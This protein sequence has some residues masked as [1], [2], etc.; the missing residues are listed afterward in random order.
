MYKN[1]DD[2]DSSW[3]WCVDHSKYHFDNQRVDQTGEWFQI[4]GRFTGR[5]DKEVAQAQG[6][7]IT[8]ATRKF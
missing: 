3:Q 5:W 7:P 2:Y 4:L 8:W 6:K 1:Q